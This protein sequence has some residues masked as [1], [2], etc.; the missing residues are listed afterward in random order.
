M[1]HKILIVDDEVA[2]CDL[3][4]INL[5]MEGFEAYISHDGKDAIS[6]I[7]DLNPDLLILDLMLPEISGFDVCKKV[8]SENPIPIIMLTAKTD[9]VDKVLGLELGA[10]DYMTKPFHARELVAR[11]KALLRRSSSEV[12]S[13]TQRKLSNG[14]LTIYPENRKVLLSGVELELSVKEYDLLSY[15]VNNTDQVLT[16]ESLLEKVWGYDF[17]GDTR[18]VDVHIQRLRKKMKDEYATE[19]LIQ[20]VFGVGYKM[21]SIE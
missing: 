20:T 3:I 1:K 9:L 4:K 6:K 19:G 7:R 21:R 14:P 18:T 5:E 17:P 11:V 8:T 16:R 13:V 15:F 12:K 2:I 10:D